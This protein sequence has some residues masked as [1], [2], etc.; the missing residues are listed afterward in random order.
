MARA[1]T[2]ILILDDGGVDD[3][4]APV[5]ALL[6]TGA[7]HHRLVA[8]GL[9]SDTSLVVSADD[10]RDTHYLACLL[11]YGADA[12][13]PGLALETVAHEAD[14]NP[15]VDLSGPEAQ[16]RL[17]AAI[18]DGVLKI[19]SKMGISTV[20]SYR[21]AQIFEAIGLG[22]EVIDTCFPGTPSIVGGIGLDELGDDALARHAN[23]RLAEGGYYRVR[24]RGEFHT[25]TD[26][27]V[28]ALN[29]MKAAHLLQSALRDA[30]A[31]VPRSRRRAAAHRLP[32]GQRQ[33]VAESY[34]RFADLV[35]GRPATELHDLLELVP[36][37]PARPPRRGGAGPG[38][39]PPLL[40]RGHV[41]TARSRPGGP[42]DP[43]RGHEPHRRPV[44][45]RRGRR[46]L[47]P[48]QHPGPGHG[49]Q[50]QPHQA[51]RLRPLRR[52]PRVLRLRRRAQIK[53]A[54]GSKPGEGGQL[55]GHKVSE[56]IAR[57]RHTQ[58]GVGL[59]SPPPHHDI[60]S[61]ED[62]AQLIFDLKQVNRHADVSVKLVAEDGVGTI[63]AGVV[64]A[65][66]D[67][68]H[69]SRRQRRHRA[70]RRSSSIKHAG[71]PWELGL[72]ETQQALIENG[73][74]DR[75]RVRVDGGF[76]T[77]RDVIM[78]ALLGADEYSFG[79]AAMIAE[80][81]I[82]LRACHK[83]TCPTGIATQRPHLRAKFAGTPEGV[84]AYMRV[85]RRGG[86]PLPGRAGLPHPRRG[87]RPGRAAPPA[88]D[89]RR[90]GRHHGPRAPARSRRPTPTAPRHFVRGVAHPAAPLG[91]GRPPGRRRLPAHVGRRRPRAAL[92]DRQ[93]RPHRR[94]RPRRGP[95]PSSSAT[96]P[97]AG[98][99][100]PSASTASAGQS[101]GAFLGHG[102]EFELV[103]EAND[104]VGK[105]MAGGRIVIR[106]AGRT[107]PATP[108][109]AG[110]TCLYGATGGELF[111]AGS[112]GERF[113]VRNS[114]AVGRG[115]GR[116]RPRLRVHDRRH[117]S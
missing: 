85:H 62:L 53:M 63:A 27:V 91:P 90:P 36:V 15:D 30:S 6:A 105:A 79:T 89:R 16:E 11:G 112:A 18:E 24:K 59:I 78:A 77:G 72:A 110:N 70:P 101:F 69:I 47:H 48:V 98:H 40:H 46:E 3:E 21:G 87:H 84:A 5:P 113:A 81:C 117:A 107:T 33:R 57:L 100:P 95:R 31:A 10:A 13:C 34:Q 116:R 8:C 109:L 111:V 9:R 12:I 83:D 54:Q 1:G 82:M 96:T 2:G 66:A 73:L 17:Q 38:H 64:K 7:V 37:R 75:V 102:I 106:P 56:E 71:L 76:M 32:A 14:H 52:D 108:V 115:R 50:E 39:H 80:G 44:Q 103:G 22:P 42:R 97:A 68:V 28:K 67:V 99:A 88:A 86:P 92:P 49:R 114:G 61:I 104:Y 41:A 58:P 25:H 19:M 29:E 94:R 93:R 45:L 60:Y 51:D 74:R 4:R 35:N 65:L 23:G 26:E 55:P 20:D 43:G